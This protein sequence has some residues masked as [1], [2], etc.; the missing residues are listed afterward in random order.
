MAWMFAGTEQDMTVGMHLHYHFLPPYMPPTPFYPHPAI[1]FIQDK[2]C[3]SVKADNRKAAKTGS[4][5]KILL[6]PHLPLLGP[7]CTGMPK[8]NTG[9]QQVWMGA[10]I[11]VHPF[12]GIGFVIL[13]GKPA[14][15]MLSNCMGCWSVAPGLD[16]MLP[17]IGLDFVMIP[18]RGVS[19]LYGPAPLALDLFVFLLAM[20]QNLF[21]WILSKVPDGFWKDVLQD[22]FDSIMVGAE[23]F[24]DAIEQGKSPGEALKAAAQ[25]TA[26]TFVD[27]CV[28]RAVNAAFAP[29]EKAI[30]D[31]W[32]G[33]AVDFVLDAGF[34][35][36]KEKI[37]SDIKEGIVGKIDDATGGFLGKGKEAIEDKD[38]RFTKAEAPNPLGPIT[39]P[40]EKVAGASNKFANAQKEAFDKNKEASAEAKGKAADAKKKMN[41]P[42]ATPEEKEAA[43]KEYNAAKKESRDAEK[44]A[45][46]IGK[47]L[48]DP[49]Q[50]IKDVGEKMADDHVKEQEKKL[51]K[52]QDKAVAGAMKD[53]IGADDNSVAGKAINHA[54]GTVPKAKEE[55]KKEEKKAPEPDFGD[56]FDAFKEENRH[57]DRKQ[58]P[59]LNPAQQK[60]Q[61]EKVQDDR[62]KMDDA[63][64]DLD[65]V[66]QPGQ[67]L[68]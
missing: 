65:A 51:Q 41:D 63:R 2:L 68:A 40:L 32:T 67:L 31:G 14:A 57:D 6:P 55:E 15:G 13:E 48:A 49:K 19:V 61:V 7:L 3:G 23:V 4:K 25:A 45:A 64:D 9:I 35:T 11:G 5:T 34:G 28:D 52:E 10:G 43:R 60:Q 58:Q 29:L 16:M 54:M 39:D 30:G 50:F 46:K 59:P 42:N 18:T 27:K 12:G 20:L 56:A 47:D 22:A 66:L 44:E 21:D 8:E 53:L 36:S 1:G 38:S 33:K 17:F 37:K 24:C 26:Y 62:A